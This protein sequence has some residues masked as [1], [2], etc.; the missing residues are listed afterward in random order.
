MWCWLF[1]VPPSV[2][3]CLLQQ[4]FC[5]M[6]SQSQWDGFR[7][8][9]V[10]LALQVESIQK[11]EDGRRQRSPFRACFSHICTVFM[12][13][14]H[15]FKGTAPSLNDLI[16]ESSPS[17]PGGGVSA[18]SRFRL[19]QRHQG[20]SFNLSLFPLPQVG[21]C[22]MNSAAGE[23]APGFQLSGEWPRRSDPSAPLDSAAWPRPE[24]TW[25]VDKVAM[26]SSE[27]GKISALF[28]W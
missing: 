22:T 9:C 21:R 6:D 14:R 1:F 5:W 8:C 15:F 7:K 2:S 12:I 4:L 17:V 26:T 25:L 20:A 27:H 18:A 19:F 13:S 3:F 16:K 10:W 28:Q 24:G 23:E 11:D